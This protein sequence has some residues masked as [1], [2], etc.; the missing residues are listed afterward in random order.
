MLTHQ[1]SQTNTTLHN[2]FWKAEKKISTVSVCI[3]PQKTLNT[4]KAKQKTACDW[5]ALDDD[6][7]LYQDDSQ[8]LKNNRCLLH[9]KEKH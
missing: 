3:F 7:H 8:T 4:I 9:N 6:C 2:L 5:T 1:A